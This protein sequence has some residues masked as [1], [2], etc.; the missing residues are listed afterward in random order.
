MPSV[1]E[2][3]PVR[4]T[5]GLIKSLNRSRILE[6]LQQHGPLSRVDLAQRTGISL[7]TVSHLVAELEEE[8]LIVCVGKG[9]SS[10][11]R[12]PVL[13][14]YNFQVAYVVGLDVGGTTVT[15]GVS[16]LEGNLLATATIPTHDDHPQPVPLTSRLKALTHRILDEAKVQPTK[17]MGIGIGVP[18]IP[19]VHK[20]TV[21]LAPGLARGQDRN[22][23]PVEL[24]IDLKT[25]LQDEFGCPIYLDNDVNTILSGERWRG[26][27]QGVQDA[28]CVTVGT[29]IGAALLINGEVHRGVRG[30]AGEIGYSL[31]GALEP[32]TRPEGYGPLESFAAGPGIARRYMQ[33]LHNSD[34]AV[35]RVLERADDGEA[36]VTARV[37]A[38]AAA[39]GDELAVDVWRETAQ[40]V[41]VALANLCLLVEPE[42]VVIGGGVSR[43]PDTLF[44]DPI[45]RIIETMVPYPPRVVSSTLDEKAGILGAVATVLDTRRNYV[46]Y[47]H[48]GV[49]G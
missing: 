34:L 32:V 23:A 12:P 33:R 16:D 48:A 43:A 36:D 46:S 30:A 3:P 40:M 35:S 39:H 45:R 29:G 18:G 14:A 10:G 25:D 31:V 9:Q 5:G 20:G 15:G 13:Y 44:L 37:V 41:G 28:L 47:V 26:V 2:N 7:P 24:E 4:G 49:G 22:G 21:K 8:D 27:L 6:C 19:D 17:L 38:E 1:N 11:G 42:V